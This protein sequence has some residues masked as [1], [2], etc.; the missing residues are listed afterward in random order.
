MDCLNLIETE[1]TPEIHLSK[2]FA[3]FSISGKSVPED[4]E[5]FF[6]PVLNW[7]ENYT[8]YPND[9]TVFNFQME[10]MNLSS[11]KMLL[12]ILYKLKEIKDDGKEVLVNWI[13]ENGD[14]DM[15]EVGEDYEFMVDIPFKFSIKEEAL[16]S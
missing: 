6:K 16:V 2:L 10:Y 7:M 1:N 15:I 12:F 11:S 8:S 5:N 9:R 4:G 14:L 3:E 13:H